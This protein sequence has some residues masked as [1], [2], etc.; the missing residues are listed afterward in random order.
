MIVVDGTEYPVR[1]SLRAL[2]KFERK[3]KM[4]VFSLSDPSKLSAE[5]CAVLC[6]VGIE[7]GCKFEGVEFDLKL[8]D[9]EANLTLSHTTELLEL[10]FASG[11]KK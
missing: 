2:K 11:K 1:F 10:L 4:S 9:I 7:D 5:A 3:T 8:E 6:F